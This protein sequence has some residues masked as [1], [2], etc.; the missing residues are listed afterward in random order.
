MLEGIL[1]G[2]ITASIMILINA[3]VRR[4]GVQTRSDRTEQKIDDIEEGQKVVFKALLALLIAQ[5]DG[6]T[7]GEC[8]DA[9]RGLNEFL[10]R[11]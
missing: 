1:I 11:K 10:I 9:L 5:R 8:E 2:I 6:K 3:L 4:A 7:N